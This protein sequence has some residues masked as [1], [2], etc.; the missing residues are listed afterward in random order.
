MFDPALFP[1]PH[2]DT[3]SLSNSAVSLRPRPL[4]EDE[5]LLYFYCFRLLLIPPMPFRSKHAPKHEK[6]IKEK[7][8]NHWHAIIFLSTES[9]GG[10]TRWLVGSLL[11][12]K[13][14]GGGSGA[15]AGG[16][17]VSVNCLR[18]KEYVVGHV[19]HTVFHSSLK[20]LQKHWK[21]L[22]NSSLLWL[23]DYQYT[24]WIFDGQFALVI[25]SATQRL[26]DFQWLNG[27]IYYGREP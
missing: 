10:Q 12:L 15:A 16:W 5:N 13:C 7:R 25:S 4:H 20:Q 2:G 21:D 26:V 24:F 18:R 1:R 14:A 22:I 23:T 9:R 19:G 17:S 8:N 6:V 3:R 27:L 11:V